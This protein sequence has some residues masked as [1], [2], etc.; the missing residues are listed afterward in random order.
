MKVSNILMRPELVRASLDG[1]KTQTR[2]TRGL[3]AVNRSPDNWRYP[4]ICTQDSSGKFGALFKSKDG[5]GNGIF[6]PCPWGRPGD[7]VWARENWQAWSEFDGVKAADIPQNARERINYPADGNKWDA[8]LRPGIHCPRWANRLTLRLKE[9][10]VERLQDISEE[11]AKAE[12]ARPAFSC[13]GWDGVAGSPS[14]RWGFH[15]L[16]Q[17]IHGPASWD[18]NDWLWVL[19]Y[20]AI[21]MNVDEVLKL[22]AA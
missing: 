10:R 9:V 11:D 1:I 21:A 2:R 19:V 6:L 13:P 3:D 16:W 7:L 17:S 20:E 14:Y 8:K 15:E 22:E 4:F 18:H 5:V 12:G